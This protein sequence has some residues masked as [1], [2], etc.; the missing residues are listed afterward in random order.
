MIMVELGKM[1]LVL[2]K[3]FRAERCVMEMDTPLGF[4]KCSAV[5]YS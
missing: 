3:E 1:G 2:G 4:C 5:Y